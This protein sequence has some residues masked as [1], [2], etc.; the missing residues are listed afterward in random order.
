M[1]IVPSLTVVFLL[2]VCMGPT[3]LTVMILSGRRE[4]GTGERIIVLATEFLTTL[5]APALSTTLTNRE[6]IIGLKTAC[7]NVVASGIF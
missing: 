4:F 5:P 7:E 6:L 2:E 3:A 1:T